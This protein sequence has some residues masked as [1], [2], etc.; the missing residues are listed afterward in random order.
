MSSKIIYLFLYLFLIE[1]QI[2]FQNETLTSINELNITDFDYFFEHIEQYPGTEKIIKMRNLLSEESSDEKDKGSKVPTLLFELFDSMAFLFYKNK[3]TYLL[4]NEKVETCFYDGVL[5]NIKN[6]QLIEIYLEGSGK[7]LN[8]FGNEF[9]CD[10]KIRRNVSYMSLH[11][12]MG[13]NKYL[14]DKEEFFDQKYFYIGLCLPR[15]CMD[16]V[17]YLI[18]DKKIKNLTHYVGLSNYKLYVNE[19]VDILSK[20]LNAFYYWFM[21]VYGILNLIKLLISI[22]RV[23]WLNKGYELFYSEK[24]GYL[25]ENLEEKFEEK[26]DEEKLEEKKESSFSGLKEENDISNS[27][28]INNTITSMDVLRLGTKE[29]SKSSEK[30][31]DI[32]TMYNKVINENIISEEENLYNPFK[33]KEKKFPTY[34]K[35][36]KVFDLFDNL[37]LL[38]SYSNRL[39]N[40]KNITNFYLIRFFIMQMNI[41]HQIMYTQIFY[42]SKNYYN[43]EF[44]S[45]V[46]FV[47]IKFCINGPTFWITIDAILFGYKLMSYLKKEV[48][49]SNGFEA[50]YKSFLKFLLLIFPRF[51]GFVFAYL[52]L[53]LYSNRLTFELAKNNKVYANYLYYND[54]IQ[55]MSYTLRNNNGTSN[56]FRNFIPFRLNYIDFIKNVTIFT[57]NNKTSE[58]NFTSDV[59]GYEI[60]S[61]F[62]TNTELFVNIYFNEFYLVLIMVLITY[63]S[64]RLKNHLFDLIILIINVILYIFPAIPAMNPY[65]GNIDERN[66]TLKY[67]LGQNYTEKFTH[68]FINFYYFGFMIGVMKFY[69]DQNIYESKKKKLLF[70]KIDLPFQFCKKVII[71]IN[72]LKLYVK[73]IILWSCVI[74]LFLIASSFSLLEGR[75]LS[76]ENN[77]EYVQVKGFTK[78]LF[79]YEK[80]LAGIFYFISLLMYICYPKSTYVNKISNSGIFILNERIS[81]CFFCSFSYVVHTQFCVFI[82]NMQISFTNILFNTV[83]I[84][85]ITFGFSLISTALLELPVR[86]MIK[87]CMNKN[88][89]KRFFNFYKLNC[90][91]S[92]NGS[93]S[94]GGFINT[95]E[96]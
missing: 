35:I 87:A 31:I 89:E 5:E 54:T 79:F 13:T 61:P 55:Q 57:H 68:Y 88:L 9:L 64:Y 26:K 74:I 14:S 19:K 51:F 75:K 78:F 3:L 82:M 28:I 90:N 84:F 93:F 76:Y 50:S 53:H 56:F 44:Y 45:S 58:D 12:Y 21:L 59:S 86:Q 73:R 17:E 1:C 20:Q 77:I 2:S 71:K 41:I 16:A 15:K 10:Y 39:Y 47:F 62:L 94:E 22:W 29:S 6:K 92:R 91:N 33:S 83:G 23:I 85:A 81:Y 96:D 11:F 27:C 43:L 4:N 38:S 34:M 7:S 65:K 8:D 30:N 69:L 40:S 32:A 60:P 37:Y 36:I 25:E 95:K 63:I 48:K 66:Y 46:W 80:N 70:G 24:Y 52:L 67:V 49:L 42:P 18:R 72:S